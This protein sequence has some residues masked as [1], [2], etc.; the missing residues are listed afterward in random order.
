MQLV[1]PEDAWEHVLDEFARQV[2]GI[3][4]IA[5][6]DGYRRGDVAIVTTIVVP[7][8]TCEP[9]YYTVTSDQMRDAGA[10]FRRYGMQR[11]AQVHTHGNS[12]I[13][14]SG[15]DDQMAYSQREG[16]LSLVLP[17]HATG[18]PHPSD[19]LLHLKMA[20]G[21][22]AL[23]PAEAETVITVIASVLDFRR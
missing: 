5:F 7:D 3:E 18:R 22:H 16:A 6:L 1:L 15:R 20:D 12:R 9:G 8:A 19:G 2:P 11:L 4:R 21:W 13:N 10:H 14:H 17:Y 23:D